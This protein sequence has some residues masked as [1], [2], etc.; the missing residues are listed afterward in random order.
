LGEGKTASCR[1]GNPRI[2]RCPTKRMAVARIMTWNLDRSISDATESLSAAGAGGSRRSERAAGRRETRW[3]YPPGT[4][5]E[6]LEDARGLRSRGELNLSSRLFGEALTAFRLDSQRERA[7]DAACGLAENLR[8]QGR[9]D[10]A[11]PLHTQLA[12]S[13]HKDGNSARWLWAVTG[14]AQIAKLQGNLEEALDLFALCAHRAHVAGELVELGYALRGTIETLCAAGRHGGEERLLATAESLFSYE[15][16]RVGLAYLAKTRGDLLLHSGEAVGACEAYATAI[17]T[18]RALGDARALAYVKAA[19]AA[20][21]ATLP[22]S[23]EAARHHF[24]I[25]LRSF[26]QS[27]VR[28]GIGIC[29]AG[30][31]RLQGR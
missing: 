16:H 20:A 22:D 24:L 11:I 26:R 7:I 12:R 19:Y 15:G 27:D 5:G 23:T 30:L 6:M 8:I 31:H 9:Y 14:L 13:S 25:A 2:A 10:L 21:L 4:L 29:Q 18:M 3:H 28:Y 1:G 17:A